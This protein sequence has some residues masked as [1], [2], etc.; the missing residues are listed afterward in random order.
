MRRT[1]SPICTSV[2]HT[3]SEESRH[4]SLFVGQVPLFKTGLFK[5]E[6]SLECTV[7]PSSHVLA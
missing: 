7:K 4:S 3:V 6:S 2:C 1:L 5:Y